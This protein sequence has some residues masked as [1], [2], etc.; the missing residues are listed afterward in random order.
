MVSMER[1]RRDE[2]LTAS[3]IVDGRRVVDSMS[4]EV[5]VVAG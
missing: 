1:Q 4:F 3:V 2:R 5:D